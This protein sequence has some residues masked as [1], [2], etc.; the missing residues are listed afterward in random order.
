MNNSTNLASNYLGKSVLKIECI[1]QT[2]KWVPI[3]GKILGKVGG[4]IT[5]L[6][7]GVYEMGRNPLLVR[8]LDWERALGELIHGPMTL[9]EEKRKVS[10]VIINCSWN[11]TNLILTL[12]VDIHLWINSIP[13]PNLGEH[14]HVCQMG[15]G[16][17]FNSKATYSFPWKKAHDHLANV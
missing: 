11:L 17:F 16:S 6:L 12:T 3:S 2:L 7:S 4:I 14:T 5:C 15:K 1:L 13:I 10:D 8:Q 9:G